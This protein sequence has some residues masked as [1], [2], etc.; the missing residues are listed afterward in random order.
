[1]LNCTLLKLLIY[2]LIRCGGLRRSGVQ[3][4]GLLKQREELQGKRLVLPIPA[5]AAMLLERSHD[6]NVGKVE[7]LLGHFIQGVAFH[8]D[9]VFV[10]EVHIEKR[11][12]K[13]VCLEKG[14]AG[15][16]TSGPLRTSASEGLLSRTLPLDSMLISF[17]I[18]LSLVTA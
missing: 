9:H 3:V 15:A 7:R 12:N 13:D 14:A 16:L 8:K 17:S 5:L 18:L 4:S 1:M 10:G 2:R 11:R 6:I